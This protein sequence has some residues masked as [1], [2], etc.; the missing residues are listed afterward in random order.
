MSKRGRKRA[1]NEFRERRRQIELKRGEP[2]ASLASTAF[3]RV[4]QPPGT[5]TRMVKT[6]SPASAQVE[7]RP[8]GPASA[9]PGTSPDVDEVYTLAEVCRLLK[10]SRSTVDR[11][12]LDGD[13][14]GRIKLRGQVRY[15]GPTV[16]QHLASLVTR[17]DKV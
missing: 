3:D 1:Q 9:K 13:L 2:T 12:H 17:V 10:V 4:Y 16:R 8:T 11:M 14:P 5:P 6:A 7:A 15:H